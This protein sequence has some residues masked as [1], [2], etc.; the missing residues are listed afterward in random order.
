MANVTSGLIYDI[1]KSIQTRLG[2]MEDRLDDMNMELQAIRGH[3]GAIQQDVANIYNR[4]GNLQDRAERV[5]VRL[6]LVD[7]AH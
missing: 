4:L 2:R 1:L 5:E 6:G 7:P 3:Q